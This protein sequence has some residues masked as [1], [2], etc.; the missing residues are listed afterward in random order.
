MAGLGEICTHITAT[1]FYVEAVVRIQGSKTCTQSQCACI[2]PS[3]M[4]S[5]DYQPIKKID[6]TSAA[7]KKWKIDEM[8]E[9]NCGE[10]Q[11]QLPQEEL[12]SDESFKYCTPSADEELNELFN[13]ISLADTKLSVLSL[14]EPYSDSYVPK[15]AHKHSKCH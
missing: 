8:L 10:P 1:L 13:N 7:G 11:E 2:I 6:F 12:V 3:Y 14:V 15:S 5:I 9:D 4:K